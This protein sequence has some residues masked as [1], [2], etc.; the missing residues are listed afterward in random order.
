MSWVTLTE[1][2]FLAQLTG[3]ETSALKSAA[4]A[5]GQTEPLTETLANVVQQV[6]GYVAANSSNRL[7][8]GVTIPQELVS[9]AVAIARYVA[10]NRLPVKSLLTD[11]RISEYRDALTLL[12]DVAA[13]KFRIEQPA[14]ISSQVIG[15]PAV[16]LVSSNTR[17]ATRTDLRGL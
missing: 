8:D 5:S 2:K 15:G 17:K 9:A 3:A 7:G 6:R 16:T 14:T 1:A 11:T 4:L 10:L 13:G 12:R